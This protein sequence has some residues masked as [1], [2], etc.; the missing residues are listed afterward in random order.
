MLGTVGRVSE[1]REKASIT[2]AHF[3]HSES[4]SC[5]FSLPNFG[6]AIQVHTALKLSQSMKSMILWLL[7]QKR[8]YSKGACSMLNTV[9]TTNLQK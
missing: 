2:V 4:Y 9:A 7:T 5:D 8:K 6:N 1:Q 3:S